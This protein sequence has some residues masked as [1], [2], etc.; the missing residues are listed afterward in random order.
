MSAIDTFKRF[1]HQYWGNWMLGRNAS[2]AVSAEARKPIRKKKTFEIMMSGPG[3]GG[4]EKMVFN[5]KVCGKGDFL[6][7]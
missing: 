3:N 1:G 5:E 2:C 7:T 4:G 6:Q